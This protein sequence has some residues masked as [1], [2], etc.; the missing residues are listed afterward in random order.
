M[1]FTSEAIRSRASPF[2]KIFDYRSISGVP[3]VAQQKR[4]RLGTMRLH[5]RSLALLIGLSCELWCRL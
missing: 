5:V 3:V 2:W 1:E 4:I